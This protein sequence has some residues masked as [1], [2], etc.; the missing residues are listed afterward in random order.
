MVSHVKLATVRDDPPRPLA[1]PP[2]RGFLKA[3]ENEVGV[4]KKAKP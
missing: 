4:L 1:T 2:G 3:L